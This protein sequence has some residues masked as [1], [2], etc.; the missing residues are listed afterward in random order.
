MLQLTLSNGIDLFDSYWAQTA[1]DW[2]IALNFSFPV[3]SI[4]EDCAPLRQLDGRRDVGHNLYDAAYACD[5]R[6]F[7]GADTAEA[8]AACSCLACSPPFTK[9]LLHSSLDEDSGDGLGNIAPAF[10]RAYIHHLLHTHEMSA[11]ALLVSHNIVVLQRFFAGIRSVLQTNP[12]DFAVEVAR[13]EGEYD[14]E[15]HI[16]DEGRRNWEAVDLARGK[17][18]LGRERTVKE[19]EAGA[20]RAPTDVVADITLGG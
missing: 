4:R 15:M 1:A 16:I 9:P 11:H 13:F 6:S 19:S 3:G 14:G 10:A 8:N 12:A 18:R 20:I 5:F 7:L 17:G 2:G